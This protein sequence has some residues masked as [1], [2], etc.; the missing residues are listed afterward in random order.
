MLCA[1]IKS[2]K[3]ERTH[4]IYVIAHLTIKG[5]YELKKEA[6]YTANIYT[7]LHTSYRAF[8]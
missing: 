7:E 2:V 4:A 6:H 1:F 8:S 3:N 5:L